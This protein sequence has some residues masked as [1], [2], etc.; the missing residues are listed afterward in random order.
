M[1]LQSLEHEPFEGLANIEVWEKDIFKIRPGAARIAKSERC[2][3]Q[4][5]EYGR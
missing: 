5:F 3:N 4:V 2:A 1:K